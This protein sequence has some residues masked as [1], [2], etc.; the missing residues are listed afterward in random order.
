MYYIANHRLGGIPCSVE[1]VCL[2]ADK[3]RRAPQ[4]AGGITGL[5]VRHDLRDEWNSRAR[6]SDVI[7]ES[8]KV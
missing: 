6:Q 4:R 5:F 1:R 3:D 7:P 2:Q 8:I